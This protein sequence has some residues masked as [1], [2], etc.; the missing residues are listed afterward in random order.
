MQNKTCTK[1]GES[2]PLGDYRSAAT[3]DGL[4]GSCRECDYAINKAY[5]ATKRGRDAH[6]KANRKYFSTDKGKLA[7]RQGSARRRAAT[8]NCEHIPYDAEAILNSTNGFC[9]YCMEQKPLTLD[10]VIPISKGGA[11]AEHNLVP[12]CQSCNSSKHNTE[13]VEWLMTRKV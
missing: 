5:A 11:D 13:L 12:C 9:C 7:K 2:K 10:H 4:R 3:R 8:A 1:C 6:T